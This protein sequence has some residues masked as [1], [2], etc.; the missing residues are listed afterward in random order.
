MALELPPVIFGTS[1]LGNLYVELTAEEKQGI[2]AAALRYS[3]KPVVFDCAGKYG[4]GL[5]LQSLGDALTKLQVPPEDVIISNKLG[6]YRVPLRGEE[7]TFEQGVWKNIKHD[8]EQRI[9]YEGIL[10]CYEQGNQLLGTYNAALVSVHDPDEYLLG[11]PDAQSRKKRFAG[12]LDAYQ[13]LF[14]LKNK[15]LVKAVGIGA[16][17][18][19]VIQEITTHIDLDWVMFANS[20]TLYSHP[21]ALSVFIKQLSDRGTWVVNSAVFNGGYLT[22]GAYFNYRLVTGED[23]AQ[24]RLIQWRKDFFETCEAFAIA[25]AHACIQYGLRVPGVSSVALN[26]TRM[27]KVKENVEMAITS[28]PSAFWDALRKKSLL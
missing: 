23:E 9:G 10:Q 1:G 11:A 7:P 16:K 22:G 21:D 26:T 8:A 14:E 27:N 24:Q 5:A 19:R 2:V 13:A 25:P 28:L 20:M 6:W 12:I 4:A 18:W 3:V 17:D 15:G